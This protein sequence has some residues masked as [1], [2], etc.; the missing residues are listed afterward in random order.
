MRK[1]LK[2]TAFGCLGLII[3]I[4]SLSTAI[5][6]TTPN[7]ININSPTPTPLISQ[8]EIEDLAKRYY[9]SHIKMKW[10]EGQF[11]EGNLTL[12]IAKRLMQDCANTFGNKDR[13]EEIIAEKFWIGMTS[14]WATMSLGNPN[15]VNTTVVNGLERR[16]FVY[17]DPIYGATYLY[18]DNGVLT[19][20]QN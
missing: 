15:D 13:C 2:F 14:D 16:Q 7:V 8:S 1:F 3:L 4:I 11:Y 19:S 6:K 9:D 20:Y 5:F 12:E 10:F 18:F 17:G